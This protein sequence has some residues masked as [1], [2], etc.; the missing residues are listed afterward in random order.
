MP[1]GST[2]IAFD[3]VTGKQLEFKSHREIVRACYKFI[4]QCVAENEKRGKTGD[5][6]FIICAI[7]KNNPALHIYPNL[8]CH[9]PEQDLEC[10]SPKM[11]YAGHLNHAEMMFSGEWRLATAE[12]EAAC[13]KQDDEQKE[14]VIKNRGAKLAEKAAGTMHEMAKAF[15]GAM[16]VQQPEAPK[17]TPPPTAGVKT[18]EHGNK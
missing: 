7:S 1:L 12:E 16:P 17:Q 4:K 10:S 6:R 8:T 3:P 18:K 2:V 5:D 15:M 11:A 9:E 14:A 13:R